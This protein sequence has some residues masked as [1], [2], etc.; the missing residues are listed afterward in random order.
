MVKTVTLNEFISTLKDEVE[1]LD[2]E[3]E[4]WTYDRVNPYTGKSIIK[5]G[6]VVCAVQ[7]KKGWLL[8]IDDATL[9]DMYF[10]SCKKAQD[11]FEEVIALKVITTYGDVW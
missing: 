10:A 4:K 11:F 1:F 6:H 5:N 9:K 8:N 3:T 2:G 7:T